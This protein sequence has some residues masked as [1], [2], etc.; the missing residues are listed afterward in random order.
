MILIICFC[1]GFLLQAQNLESEYAAQFS[2]E[3][4]EIYDLKNDSAV[5][6]KGQEIYEAV[7]FACHGRDLEGATAPNLRDGEWLH[8]SKPSEILNT[9]KNGFPTKG[10]VEFQTIYNDE[11]LNAVT[12]YLLS[13]QQGLRNVQYKLY[14]TYDFEPVVETSNDTKKFIKSPIPNLK[15]STH[16]KQGYLHNNF[17]DVY[18]A[19]VMVYA[20]EFESYLIVPQE[21]EYSFT[22]A[23]RLMPCELYIDGKKLFTSYKQKMKS[24]IKKKIQLGKGVH[25]IQATYFKMGGTKSPRLFFTWS[26]PGFED[27]PL[28]LDSKKS[29][30]V[31]YFID[32]QH[33]PKVYRGSMEGFPSSSLYLG[34]PNQLNY[35]FGSRSCQILGLW[36]GDFLDIGGAISNRGDAPSEPLGSWVFKNPSQ[37]TLSIDDQISVT[38]FKGY[39]LTDHATILK[40][41]IKGKRMHTVQLRTSTNEEGQLVFDYSITPPPAGKVSLSVPQGLVVSSNDG[42]VSNSNF[43]VDPSKN[44]RF[45]FLISNPK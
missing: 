18:I 1:H 41:Q 22:F 16:E 34:F 44:S 20:V 33:Q 10:M 23:S 7:C 43:N 39:E 31:T 19:E 28:S 25:K 13:R 17:L 3:D 35:V 8:G 38:S 2:K 24:N 37:I 21:A 6:Q 29:L 27:Q 12:A 15:I 42:N 26:G 5:V 30:K 40:Y 4:R 36:S 11:Q 14:H 32:L 45:K 9:I